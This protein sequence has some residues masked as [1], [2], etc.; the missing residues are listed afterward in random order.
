MVILAKARMP[1]GTKIQLEDWAEDFNY[2]SFTV[3]TYPIARNTSK[4]AWVKKGENFRLSL[5]FFK[6]K[7]KAEQVFQELQDGKP[8]EEYEEFFWNPTRYRFYLGM[9]E[10]EFA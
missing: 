10:M 9:S 8:L 5:E 2:P 3:G 1:D 6:D 7:G 4:W